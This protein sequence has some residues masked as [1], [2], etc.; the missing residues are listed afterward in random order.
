VGATVGGAL[1]A[2][3]LHRR[4]WR[5]P[6][7]TVPVIGVVVAAVAGG[8]LAEVIARDPLTPRIHRAHRHPRRRSSARARSDRLRQATHLPRTRP[9]RQAVSRPGRRRARTNGRAAVPCT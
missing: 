4:V 3:P 5:I 9:C 8:V 7:E 2:G 1:L 6:P